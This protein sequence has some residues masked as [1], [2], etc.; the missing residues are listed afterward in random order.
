MRSA[1]I[2]FTTVLS[3]KKVTASIALAYYSFT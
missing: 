1:E 3:T 2:N